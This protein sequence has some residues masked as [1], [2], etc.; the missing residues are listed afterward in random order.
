MG[1]GAGSTG[2]G[3]VAT[4]ADGGGG[5]GAWMGGASPARDGDGRKG[6]RCG[7]PHLHEAFYGT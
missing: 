7:N 3:A 1:S 5:G 2:G 4:V 6:E